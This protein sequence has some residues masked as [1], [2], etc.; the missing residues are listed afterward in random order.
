MEAIKNL[1]DRI[2]TTYSQNPQ[3]LVYTIILGLLC[4]L[5]KIYYP[6]F[7]WFM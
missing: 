1:F 4:V 7:R 5:L 3:L 2:I 6:K